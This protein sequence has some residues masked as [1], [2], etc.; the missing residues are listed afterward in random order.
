L[1]QHGDKLS[2]A[3]RESKGPRPDWRTKAACRGYMSASGDPWDA[4]PKDGFVSTTAA[5]FCKQC[6]VRRECLLEGLRSDLLNGGAAYGVWG[7]LSPKERRALIRLRY[8]VACPVCRGQLIITSEG[9]EWQAC[10]SCA[11][12]WRC[13]KREPVDTEPLRPV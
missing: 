3:P 1:T 6:P 11:V 9:E 12:T 10:A 2:G 7:G 13:R 4:D 5:A 8:R